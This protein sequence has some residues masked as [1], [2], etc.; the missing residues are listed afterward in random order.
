MLGVVSDGALYELEAL[1]EK[2]VV[3]MQVDKTDV[4]N[5]EARPAC[6]RKSLKLFYIVGKDRR[7]I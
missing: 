2:F 1:V 7:G 3:G 6:H 5:F 4:L